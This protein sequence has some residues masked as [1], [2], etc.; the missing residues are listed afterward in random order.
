MRK[1]S[2]IVLIFTFFLYG[3]CVG[4]ELR[5][6]AFKEGEYIPSRYS[7]DSFDYSPPLVWDDVPQGTRSFALIC[8]D[9]DAPTGIW[10]HW[11][12]F[13]IPYQT[14]SLEESVPKIPQLPNGAIQ[15][16]NDF[17][18]VGYGG[19]CPPSGKPHRYFFK[20]YA[21][22]TELNLREGV[23][24]NELMKALEGHILDKASLYGL[25]KR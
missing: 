19:P 13:N 3:S 9:P 5:S 15:G 1:K 11:V 6:P 23:T 22:D 17:N 16:V 14:H 24:R 2:I 4:L 10:V 12:I 20:L 8:E 25:Y 21:L 7:C 18:R